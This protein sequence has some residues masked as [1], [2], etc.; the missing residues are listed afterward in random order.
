MSE[1]SLC[2]PPFGLPENIISQL[3]STYCDGRSF[4]TFF[5]VL[6]GNRTLCS[7]AFSV[8]R[9]ALVD[10]YI[11]LASP[12]T[13]IGENREIR[14][15]L[16][17]IREDIRT[18]SVIQ[19]DTDGRL[20]CNHDE[21]SDVSTL[22]SEWCAIL[23][24]FDYMRLRKG[25]DFVLW[26]G[27]MHSQGLGTMEVTYL[28]SSFWT[29]TSMDYLYKELELNNHCLTHPAIDTLH[30]DVSHYGILEVGTKEDIEILNRIRY[31]MSPDLAS[32]SRYNILVPGHQEY[33]PTMG[34]SRPEESTFL[35]S[36]QGRH[37][38][39]LA[40]LWVGHDEGGD[41]EHS[42]SR[43]GENVIRILSRM[44]GRR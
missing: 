30:P 19:S 20:V 28:S 24:Y 12:E 11:T 34:F 5:H 15:C 44:E 40:F 14:D 27:P 29:V 41:F 37:N 43:L 33:E 23:D 2:N 18:C 35:D 16:D 13:Y 32:G 22:V 8:L 38:H 1:L 42:L 6:L 4:S 7:F 39:S 3:L 10:R 36:Y 26:C 25:H 31:G 17:I 9:D 21:Y